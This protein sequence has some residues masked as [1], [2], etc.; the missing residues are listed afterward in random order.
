MLLSLAAADRRNLRR[1]LALLAVIV[2]AG[3]IIVE[4][5]LNRLTQRQEFAQALG[6]RR[7][8][9]GCWRAYALGASAGM[10][11]VYPVG[12]IAS[13][14]RSLTIG[15]TGRSV[16]LPT[17]LSMN[18]DR[19]LYWLEVWRRQFVTEA[20]KTKEELEALIGQLRP[21][22]RKMAEDVRR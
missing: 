10:Q 17:L 8:A 2:V 19:P 21:L 18:I 3:V 15:L 12:I 22:I 20:F 7:E 16:T 4:T 14:D 1:G 11:A 6:L 5:Q 13:T 9:D